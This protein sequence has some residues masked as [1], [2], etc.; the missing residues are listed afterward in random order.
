MALEK[1]NFNIPAG[2]KWGVADVEK[3]AKELGL[4]NKSELVVMALDMMMKLRKLDIDDI[5]SFAIVVDLLSDG[6][7]V[8]YSITLTTKDGD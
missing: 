1:I 5:R 6:R 7:N 3:R 4:Q 8:D 2:S